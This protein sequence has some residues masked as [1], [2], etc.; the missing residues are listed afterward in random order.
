MMPVIES[1]TAIDLDKARIVMSFFDVKL[2]TSVAVLTNTTA[3]TASNSDVALYIAP[4]A[5][6]GAAYPALVAVWDNEQDAIFDT[7]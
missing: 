4:H 2:E 7:I 6:D 3:G 1:E 5:L